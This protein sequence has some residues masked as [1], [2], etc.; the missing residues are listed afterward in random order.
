MKQ[1]LQS[2]LMKILK[3]AVELAQKSAIN[4]ISS[5]SVEFSGEVPLL[6]KRRM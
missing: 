2:K 5:G 1:K 6:L 3:E 4:E